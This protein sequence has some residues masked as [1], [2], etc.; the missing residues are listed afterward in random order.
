METLNNCE[1]R[2]VSLII[3]FLNEEDGIQLCCAALDHY[4][5]Q[6]GFP[7]EL[8]FV[9]DGSTDRSQQM[10]A[11]YPFR[12]VRHV[13]LVELSRNFGAHAAG[14]AGLQYAAY[15]ICTFFGSDLQ[16]PLELLDISYKKIQQGY[17]AVYV[18]KN[19]LK[20]SGLTKCFSRIYSMLIK[21]FAVHNYQSGGT[22]TIVFNG[23]IKK[24]L[25][26]HVET[27]S[28]LLLQIM[29]AGYK[30][31]V[32]ALDYGQRAAGKSKWTFSKKIKLFIDSFAAFSY[33]PVR[34]ISIA[35]IF[36]S[37]TGIAGSM[38]AFASRN[39]PDRTI[40][41]DQG[42]RTRRNWYQI[43]TGITILGFGVTNISL[44]ILAEYLW[45]AYDAARKR[46]AFLVSDVR[47]LK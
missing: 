18:E 3:P 24:Y 27:N 16:E 34:L 26:E 32:I 43:Q 47:K 6:S 23:K 4:A 7:L 17:D 38:A 9:D 28:S 15:D 39:M 22:A 40:Q 10:L 20:A 44:G 5:E 12:Y 13:K 36:M 8:V 2:G 1:G 46:P 31:T 33:M 41:T 30:S 21:K 25:N 29:D 37:L 14:R 19:S 35:G 42:K 45:R 11:A